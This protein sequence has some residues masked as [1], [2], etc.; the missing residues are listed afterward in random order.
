[1]KFICCV[2][3]DSIRK[4]QKETINKVSNEILL[5]IRLITN[6]NESTTLTQNENRKS[7]L[8]SNDVKVSPKNNKEKNKNI[9]KRD[10]KILPI[11]N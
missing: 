11:I 4:K 9:I 5:K 7:T 8:M 1:V 10:L 6:I 2:N 3:N